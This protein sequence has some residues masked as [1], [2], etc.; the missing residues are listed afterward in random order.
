[1]AIVGWGIVRAR[2]VASR[3]D[4]GLRSLL[5]GKPTAPGLNFIAEIL[6]GERH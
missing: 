5:A 6:V 1:M 3:I 2:S 4:A